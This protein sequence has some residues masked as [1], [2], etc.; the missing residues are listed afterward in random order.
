MEITELNRA[1]FCALPW[2][3]LNAPA[4]Q[5][6]LK[7]DTVVW[8]ELQTKPKVRTLPKGLVVTM[9]HCI[10]AAIIVYDNCIVGRI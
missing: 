1:K 3:P 10:D 7:A 2:G 9:K 4:F 8:D 6:T 5:H